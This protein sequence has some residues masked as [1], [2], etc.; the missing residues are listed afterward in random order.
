[1]SVAHTL[2]S[3]A[4]DRPVAVTVAVTVLGYGLVIGTFLGIIDFYPDLSKGTVDLLTHLIAI[5]NTGALAA[6]VA[7]VYFISQRE[8]TKHATSMLIAFSLILLFLVVYV[9]RVG[10]GET[11]AI[12]APDLVTTVYRAM[13]AIHILL[14]IVSVPVVVYAVVLGLTRTPAELAESLKST[15]GRLAASAWILSLAL[16]IITYFMLNH[17]YDSE[18]LNSVVFLG[19]VGLRPALS[20]GLASLFDD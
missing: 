10:G 15:V 2:K 12:V 7:G 16:G 9:F 18:P 4:R 8:I 1:M 5:I 14:S 17:V 19:A 13:L 6:L 11:K 20:D 3:S